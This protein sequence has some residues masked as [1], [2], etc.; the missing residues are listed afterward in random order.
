[1]SENNDTKNEIQ[2]VETQ[3]VAILETVSYEEFGLNKDFAAKLVSGLE[4]HLA[5]RE[6]LKESYLALIPQEVTK[7][8]AK[9]ARELRLKIAKNRTKG[10]NVWHRTEK[11]VHLAA[12]KLL[13]AVKRKEVAVNQDW[14][15]KLLA[16]ENHFENLEKER[17][18][19]LEKERIEE[20]A[21]FGVEG[22]T[23]HLGSMP[24]AV[25][26]NFLTGTRAKFEKDEAEKAENERKQNLLNERMAIISEFGEYA[27]EKPTLE[28]SDE[29]WDRILKLAQDNEAEA[30]RVA[31]LEK[32]FKSRKEELLPLSDFCDIS[33]L[34]IETTEEE[35]NELISSA[36]A[37]KEA[38]KVKAELKSKRAKEIAPYW[39]FLSQEEIDQDFSDFSEEEWTA[40]I[41]S[42]S[43]AKQE[44]EANEKLHS[45]R[46]AK[47]TPYLIDP[48]ESGY[49][50][51]ELTEGEFDQRFKKLKSK[52]EEAEAEKK[53]EAERV[54][55]LERKQKLREKR[56]PELRPYI[57]F[58]RDY[59]GLI[60]SD[61]ESY[62][63]QLAEIKKG[64]EQH[65]EYERK[66]KAETEAEAK[67]QQ[68]LNE[69]PDKEKMIH[70]ISS[71]SLP[72][73]DLST[74]DGKAV[75]ANVI[76]KFNGFSS[77]SN[78]EIQKFNKE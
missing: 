30:E 63:T 9:E 66:K 1:M 69:G 47:I 20:I 74:E 51:S 23:L 73:I 54:A 76:Q 10:I 6:L 3:E 62:Q 53:A 42:W 5:E 29:D 64:A 17:I 21:K 72:E 12:S 71:V 2:V 65:W 28:T 78:K 67:R 11:D 56:E 59:S 32:V 70:A 27:T 52:F 19:N 57:T 7:E 61:E 14:E 38:E 4:T 18:E 36:K 37:S 34:T 39:D 77:W 8:T 25:W 35:F 43:S 26:D 75:W 15:E 16:V 49:D 44:K 40:K 60:E 13:D 33:D 24:D 55:E 48:L 41:E 45:D 58:I 46:L 50:L 31:E 22:E 68:E